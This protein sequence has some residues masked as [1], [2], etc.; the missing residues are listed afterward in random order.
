MTGTARTYA[1]V[2]QIR[3]MDR[4]RARILPNVCLLLAVCGRRACHGWLLED[5]R[6]VLVGRR[7]LVLCPVVGYMAE[8]LIGSGYACAL[9]FMERAGVDKLPKQIARVEVVFLT[10]FIG[11]LGQ[12]PVVKAGTEGAD[13]GLVVLGAVVLA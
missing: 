6:L 3:C 9:S 8:D 2:V 10:G 11:P 1:V 13:D 5:V 12:L 4:A 7:N